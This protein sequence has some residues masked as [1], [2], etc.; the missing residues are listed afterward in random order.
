MRL[1]AHTHT[2]IIFFLCSDVDCVKGS[3]KIEL[4]SDSVQFNP[5]LVGLLFIPLYSLR[6]SNKVLQPDHIHDNLD[7]FCCSLEKVHG[8]TCSYL[9]LLAHSHKPTIKYNLTL[10]LSFLKACMMIYTAWHS[11]YITIDLPVETM[12]LLE[13][14]LSKLEIVKKREVSHYGCCKHHHAVCS[15]LLLRHNRS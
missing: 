9:L 3:L 7:P 15:C 4:L 1:H 10:I 12:A 2:H 13:D 14:K 5:Q 6:H 11:S 8:R